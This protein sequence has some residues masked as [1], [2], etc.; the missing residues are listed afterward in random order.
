MEAIKKHEGDIIAGM[1]KA[2]FN[3]KQVRRE[4]SF[5]KQ[6]WDDPKNEYLRK[7]TPLSVAQSIVNVANIGLTLN[8]VSGEAYLVPRYDKYSKAIQCHLEPSYKGFFKLLTDAGTVTSINP[9][10]VYEGDEFDV[11]LGMNVSVKHKPFYITGNEQGKMKGAYCVAT[12][13]TGSKQFE[14]M[15]AEDIYKIRDSSE[16]WKSFSAGKA[17]SAI[18]NDWGGEMARKTVVRR[19]YKYLPKSSVKS[20]EYEKIDAAISLMNE[21]FT[22]STDQ[23]E[24]LQKLLRTSSLPEHEIEQIETEMPTMSSTGATEAIQY[25][26]ANQRNK[27]ESGDNYQASD[28]HE[29]LDLKMQD[30]KAWK[31]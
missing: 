2:G 15:T 31:H 3:E 12:L 20:A 21:N 24:Y 28:I 4:L 11:E 19:I 27:I 23:M 16:S 14:Y 17:K 1:K 8:P 7:A 22:P 9:Q 10:V 26:A 13:P 18:W 30:E 25:L 29:Q 6:I 5:A